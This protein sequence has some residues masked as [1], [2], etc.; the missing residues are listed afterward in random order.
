MTFGHCSMLSGWH[1][2]PPYVI[3]MSYDNVIMSSGW[4]TLPLLSHLDEIANFDLPQH[5]VALQRFR[6]ILH[7][8]PEQGRLP[9]D[10]V[11]KWK[12]FPRYWPPVLRIHRSPVNS[13]HTAQFHDVSMFSFICA[14]INTWVNNRKAGDYRR[15]RAHYDVIV[16]WW[17]M[18][19]LLSS[20]PCQVNETDLM[21]GY[22]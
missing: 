10:D 19:E 16:M 11:I 12:H 20:H 7:Q 21:M 18:L 15:H 4:H 1:I 17:P 2:I 3:R 6:S 9:H 8:R 22:P 13:P 5:A 14:W